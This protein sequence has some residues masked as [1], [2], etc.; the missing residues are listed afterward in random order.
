MEF[1]RILRNVTQ[2]ILSEVWISADFGRTLWVLRNVAQKYLVGRVDFQWNFVWLW[3]W[4]DF[5]LIFRNVVQY[6]A[7]MTTP[8]VS[9]FI[10]SMLKPI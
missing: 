5:G 9:L 7:H 6:F 10:E 1:D 2:K 3:I 8:R 4:A